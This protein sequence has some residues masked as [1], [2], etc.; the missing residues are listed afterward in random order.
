MEAEGLEREV[1]NLRLSEEV[2]SQ[3]FH[4]AMLCSLQSTEQRGEQERLMV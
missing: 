3:P 4:Y 2:E 1:T